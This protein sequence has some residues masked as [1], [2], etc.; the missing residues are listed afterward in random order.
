MRRFGLARPVH[1]PAPAP[2]RPAAA[3]R[4]RRRIRRPAGPMR[5]LLGGVL[6]VVAVM[7]LAV[8]G[9]TASGWPLGDA[10]YMTVITVFTVGY[11]EVRPISDPAV[12]AI[13]VSLIVFGCS[14]TIFVTGALVQLI[15]FSQ[16]DAILGSRRMRARIDRLADHVIVCGW[17]RIGRT[18]TRELAAAGTPFVVLERDPE[19]SDAARALGYLVSAADATDEQALLAAGINRARTLATVL[20]DDAANVFITLSARS[21]NARLAIIARGEAS[22]TERKLLQAGADRVVLPTRIGAERI[23]E[24]ILYPDLSSSLGRDGA[25]PG[26]AAELSRLGLEL[27]VVLVEPGSPFAGCRVD[28]IERHAEHGFLV[29]SVQQYPDAPRRRAE[30]DG[31]V[32]AG[33]G[34]TLVTRTGRAASLHGF[35]APAPDS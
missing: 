6:F 5:N 19:R 13:T 24:I 25:D 20:P 8:L 35:L 4:S 27:H 30:P 3:P 32:P 12:R 31:R 16:L 21:L 15:T 7:V 17:G 34:L 33:A 10:A 23:A 1:P 29:L 9:Y 14:G 18:L 2:G 11:E 22:A 28:E 26:T